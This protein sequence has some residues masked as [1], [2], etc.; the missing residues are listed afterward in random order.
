MLVLSMPVC[1]TF[2]VYKDLIMVTFPAFCDGVIHILAFDH[3][4][5]DIAPSPCC[6]RRNRSR[7][8]CWTPHRHWTRAPSPPRVCL[9]Y[10][11]FR[12]R[13]QIFTC[14]GCKRESAT[15]RWVCLFLRLLCRILCAVQ[16]W[17]MWVARVVVKI[18]SHW[19]WYCDQFRIHSWPI[20]RCGEESWYTWVQLA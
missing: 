9:A 4:P 12:F 13:S 3:L 8:L 11:V 2:L 6:L 15:G 17:D 7:L 18:S 1:M 19:S 14:R 16:Q 10:R 5:S 20:L